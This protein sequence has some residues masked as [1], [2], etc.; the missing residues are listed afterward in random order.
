VDPVTLC[1]LPSR[2]KS[3]MAETLVGTDT[4]NASWPRL[5]LNQNVLVSFRDG[6]FVLC[7]RLRGN[8]GWTELIQLSKNTDDYSF[9]LP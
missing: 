5:Q 1:I 2:K 4:R 9:D 3:I 7:Q 8:L 6:K